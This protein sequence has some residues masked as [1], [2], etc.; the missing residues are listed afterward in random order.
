MKFSPGDKVAFINEK[1][2]GIV[3]KILEGDKVVVA[4]EEGF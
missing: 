2:D 1:Q 3:V 4:I